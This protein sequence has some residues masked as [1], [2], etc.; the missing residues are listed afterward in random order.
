MAR[1]SPRQACI[2]GIGAS[3][4][5][6][7]TGRS[8]LSLCADAFKAAMADSGL[9]REEVDGLSIHLG[10]PAMTALPRGSG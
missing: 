10:S 1:N 4:F 3:A 9:K 2:V 8:P 6:R 5:G 7:R